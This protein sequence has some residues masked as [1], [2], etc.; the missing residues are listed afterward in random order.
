MVH[1]FL[2]SP[3]VYPDFLNFHRS[4]VRSS[5]AWVDPVDAVRMMVNN[6]V[7]VR[8]PTLSMA[9]LFFVRGW[10]NANLSTWADDGNRP[11]ARAKLVEMAQ[12]HAYNKPL[13]NIMKISI[14][15]YCRPLFGPFLC[16]IWSQKGTNV[17]LK[18]R[19]VT[20]S[21]PEETS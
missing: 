19:N 18:S 14:L 7:L 2:S 17:I 1:R 16:S 10:Y 12:S 20:Q 11:G 21:D 15:V 8:G 4:S 5:S 9:C 6:P 13:N 3:E